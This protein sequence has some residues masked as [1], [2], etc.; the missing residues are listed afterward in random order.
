MAVA[1][2]S[3]IDYFRHLQA[4]YAKVLIDAPGQWVE[5]LLGLAFD[6]FAR[7]TRDAESR[8]PGIECAKGCST[9]CS[10]RVTVTA[11]EVL[12]LSRVIRQ[13]HDRLLRRGI[14]L[15]DRVALAN[16]QTCGKGE[17][18]RVAARV[19]CPFVAQGACAI[20]AY[21]P[22]ACR[23]MA[24]HDRQVCARAAAGQAQEIAHSVA[25]L[26]TRALV[27]NAMQSALR[28]AGLAWHNYELIQ[29]LHIALS[30]PDAEARW[31]SGDDPLRAA[32]VWDVDAD[33]MAITFEQIRQMS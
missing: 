11:P 7:N 17:D 3:A 19:R 10:L 8:T 23:G 21:R 27:Q 2:L 26:N 9:C 13:I 29:A 6:S 14:D 22:L 33:D 18:D 1:T 28:D 15:P 25:H 12:L 16:Q 24:S 32:R 4:A 20:Y 30:A 31:L 5:N